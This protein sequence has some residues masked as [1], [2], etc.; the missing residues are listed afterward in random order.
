[1]GHKDPI[2]GKFYDFFGNFVKLRGIHD[3]FIGDAGQR[4]DVIGYV[5]FRVDK[6]YKLISN[7]LTVE[8]I[9]GDFRYFFGL[10]ASACSL[11]VHNGIQGI[12]LL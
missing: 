2:L 5:L 1:M 4:G 7:P 6:G 3:H 11:Y 10:R 9:N 8:M 12:I